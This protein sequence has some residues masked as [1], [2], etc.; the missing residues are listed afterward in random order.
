MKNNRFVAAVMIP[1]VI[2]MFIFVVFPVVYGLAISFYDYNP[3]NSHNLF[4]GFANYKRM[5]DDPTFWLSLKNTVFFGLV[6]LI[7]N[8]I[9]IFLIFQKQFIRGLTMSG[10]K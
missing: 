10:M 6:T 5:L 2:Y 3:A 7:L 1:S 8:L 9:I 4:L